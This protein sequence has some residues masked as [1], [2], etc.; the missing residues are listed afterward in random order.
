MSKTLLTSASDKSQQ[1]GQKWGETL[2]KVAVVLVKGL[3]LG[4]ILMTM[5]VNAG[6][7]VV[8]SWNQIKGIAIGLALAVVVLKVSVVAYR[9]ALV[10]VAAAQ[11]AWKAMLWLTVAAQH[12]H[13]GAML[14]LHAALII[15]M[16]RTQGVTAVMG[17]FAAASA[18]ASLAM[19]GPAA[20][21]V[22]AG[23]AG[24]A[25]G[26]M[27]DDAFGL[28]DRMSKLLLDIAGVTDELGKLDEAYNRTVAK[29][30]LDGVETVRVTASPEARAAAR[31]I[32]ASEGQPVGTN[33]IIDSGSQTQAA[34]ISR[35]QGGAFAAQSNDQIQVTQELLELLRGSEAGRV[36][37]D[38]VVNFNV[39]GETLQSLRT[40]LN[41]SQET[42]SAG[43]FSD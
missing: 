35:E 14:R 43:S 28:S 29:R 10:A 39:D 3:T 13:L 34:K 30:G 36:S 42:G 32:V 41:S 2:G 5:L 38:T 16:I 9:V 15:T 1:S 20:L 40:R 12:A 19:L 11:L 17:L 7:A 21:V 23:A 24:V 6:S 22:A 18:R 37:S 4:V 27:A 8:D 26:S 25:L 31:E 33:A